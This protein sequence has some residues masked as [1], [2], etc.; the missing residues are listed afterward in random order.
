MWESIPTLVKPYLNAVLIGIG[1]ILAAFIA[2]QVTSRL[3]SR[4]MGKG[5]SRF[6]SSLV[7][8]VI[9]IWTVKLILDSAGAVGLIL[10]LVTAITGAFAL[11][12]ERFAGDLVSGI[13]LFSIKSYEVGD[14]VQLAGQEGNVTD[15][16][17]MVTTLQNV[18]GDRIYIRNSDVT[19]TTIINYFSV[20]NDKG[21]S[22]AGI[23]VKL[24]L[25]V[26]QDLNVAVSAI[27][28]AIKDF[29]PDFKNSDSIYQPSVVVETTTPGH[30][31]LEV[32]AYVT[33]R[34]DYGSEKTRLFL[35]AANAVKDAGLSLKL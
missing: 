3:L 9:G 8:L 15:I 24:A 11:G 7:A 29:A 32:C 1:G 28:N 2:S 6:V 27:E 17:L 18:Q 30:F 19:S 34:K 23:S 14:T 4:P 21:Q 5:W 25:P 10:V 12:S 16:S 31:T 33:E 13:S 22:S 20:V 26:T 35:L